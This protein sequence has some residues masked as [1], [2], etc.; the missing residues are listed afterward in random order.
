VQSNRSP[1]S[2]LPRRI[3]RV[4]N[5][6]G[7]RH[8][9]QLQVPFFPSVFCERDREI[10]GGR[11]RRGPSR[12]GTS[13]IRPPPSHFIWIW[14]LGDGGRHAR[15]GA[16]LACTHA[17]GWWPTAARSHVDGG[18]RLPCRMCCSKRMRAGGRAARK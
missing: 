3:G 14:R 4:G 15:I 9:C 8:S 5:Q 12:L 17:W 2:S 6:D 16:M 13:Q 11:R 18:R 10:G 1:A 7:R